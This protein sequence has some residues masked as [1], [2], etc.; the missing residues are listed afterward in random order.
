MTAIEDKFQD[1]LNGGLNLGNKVGI[2]ETTFDGGG[3]QR[4][5]FGVIYFNPN[6]GAAFEAHGL[7]LDEYV[8]R[9]EMLSELAYPTSDELDDAGVV[10]GRVSTFDFGSIAF[11]PSH[12]I[13]VIPD[14]P[15]AFAPQ[16]VVKVLDSIV[17]D[18]GQGN[19]IG[20][21]EFG[22]FAGPAGA[23]VAQVLLTILPDLSLHRLFDSLDAGSINA[24]VTQATDEDPT[25]QPPS[26]EHFLEI[27][28]PPGFDTSGLVAALSA[29]ASVV[30]F[31]YEVEDPSDPA[32]APND[33]PKFAS[34]GYLS[35]GASGIGVQ[36]AWNRNVDGSGKNVIDLEQG[37]FLRHEDLPSGITLLKG[38][39]SPASF[40]HGCAVLGEIVG[41]DN[42]TGIV[43]IAPQST[44]S[45]ISYFSKD[46]F[47]SLASRKR[48]ASSVMFAGALLAPGKDAAGDFGDGGVL[49]IEAQ[50]AATF[51]GQRRLAPVEV[52]PAV[53][54]AIRLLTKAR[55][56]VVEPAGNG[57]G[58]LDTFAPGGKRVLDRTSADFKE[59]GAIM[60]AA[61]MAATPHLRLTNASSQPSSQT[62]VGSRMDCY[63]WGERIVTTGFSANT[64]SAINRY[65]ESPTFFG[66]TS[67]AAPIIAGC[68]LL[69]Q[70]LQATLA[71]TS[72]ITG[73]MGAFR[74]RQV[75]SDPANGTTSTD[76]IGVMPDFA[77]LIANEYT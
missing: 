44:A 43:G 76:P 28:C 13:N 16:V 34:Q 67:G 69:L 42:T 51:S 2:E 10:G 30:E 61:A 20:A 60:V 72:G 73:A 57:G 25:Y 4:H 70:G 75:L 37:W 22:A 40:A 31:A 9:G 6:V 65:F 59:S 64:P 49:L 27:D 45:T 35:A 54:E 5:D 71:P 24:I 19:S 8:Q 12:G 62:N 58:N 7:I 52:D 39:N 56:I 32:V 1:L 68:V 47:D 14:P 77:K 23:L 21:D 33:D 18:L 53:F 15:P 11:D 50:I 17:V 55:V 66:G 48:I 74:T 41:V 36:A 46:R 26:F 29:F 3:L 38:T 63:A